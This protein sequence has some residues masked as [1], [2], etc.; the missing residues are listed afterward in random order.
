MSE[1]EELFGEDG[2]QPKTRT[3][4]G[5]TLLIIGGLSSLFG[6]FCTVVPGAGLILIAWLIAETDI[7][8][9]ESGY[10]PEVL[11]ADLRRL[12]LSTHAGVIAAIVL[13]AVQALVLSGLIPLAV[14]THAAG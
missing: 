1:L 13:L 11:R 4:L 7:D 2:G 14:H 6:L 8:R 3:T 9:L 10:L 12:Q 5:W